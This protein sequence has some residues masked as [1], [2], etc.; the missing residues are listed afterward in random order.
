MSQR[1]IPCLDIKD[2]QV[3]K[4]V[5]FEGLKEMGDPLDLARAYDAQGADALVILDIV[6]KPEERP[7][8][9]D[10][11]QA[12]CQAVSLPVIAGGGIRA[13]DDLA[14]V[15]AA[16]ASQAAMASAALKDP[17]LL[18]RAAASYGSEKIVLAIDAARRPQGQ[19]YQIVL[20]GGRD[21]FDQ[22]P[23]AW[24]QEGERRGAGQ[25]LLTSLDADGGQA[26]FDLDLN[27]AVS[28]AVAIPVIASGGAGSVDDFVQVFAQTRVDAALAASLFHQ[29]RVAVA[30]IRRALTRSVD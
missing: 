20:A 27:D 15:F 28:R 23:I 24:A 6:G 29:G 9:L 4:G 14:P 21:R 16:G 10:L 18:S 5:R 30:D 13:F 2:G 7:H 25:I 22:D 12:V 1:I 17:D 26:G 3:V 8:F 11:L 19:G